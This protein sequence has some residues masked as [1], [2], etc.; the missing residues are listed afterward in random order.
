M[1]FLPHEPVCFTPEFVA[2]A[3]LSNSS[4]SSSPSA[5]S[6]LRLR[7]HLDRRHSP[8]RL[9]IVLVVIVT[10]IVVLIIVVTITT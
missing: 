2:E 10:I 3:F 8:S 7:H 1:A 6:V 9:I 4:L 5:P